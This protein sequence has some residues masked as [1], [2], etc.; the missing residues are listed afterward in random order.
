[1]EILRLKIDRVTFAN[2]ETGYVVL[3][4]LAR[5]RNVTAVGI[6]PDVI[7]NTNLVGAEY[8]FKGNWETSKYG[9]QFSFKQA[10]LLTNQLFYFLSKIVKGLGEK[11]SR[12]LISHYGETRLLEILEHEPEKLTEFKGIK[13][14]KL[15]KI[16]ASWEKQK[17]LR[18]LS[19]YLLPHGI[20][21]S[22]LIRIHNHFGNEAIKK[23]KENPYSL[24]EIRGIGFKTADEIA[25]KLGIEFNSSFRIQSAIG[26]ILLEAAEDEGHT[27]LPIETLYEKLKEI[28]DSEEKKVSPE[29]I[30]EAINILSAQGR[31]Y[32][33][34]ARGERQEARGERRG[35]KGEG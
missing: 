22:L 23:I 33:E 9:H 1:M 14:K 2:P 18:E 19:Q 16:K 34:G 12:D 35:V 4:G 8:E 25:I 32:V 21:P 10:R 13:E 27:Y 30:R 3:K 29:S 6:L 28:L 26:H 7:T 17:N 31:L 11:L 5:K 20:T 24:T 15:A